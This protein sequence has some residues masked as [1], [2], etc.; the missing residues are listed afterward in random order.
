M[1]KFTPE[2]KPVSSDSFNIQIKLSGRQRHHA[3]WGLVLV[4][5]ENIDLYDE[6][7]EINSAHM[8]VR[9]RRGNVIFLDGQFELERNTDTV[10]F[11]Q[12]RT[13]FTCFY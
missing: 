8:A 12:F 6:M 5:D 1:S 9:G 10:L 13:G 4:F 11:I 3:E 7:I 2:N